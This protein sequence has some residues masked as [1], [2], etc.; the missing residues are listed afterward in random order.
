MSKLKILA[1]CSVLLLLTAE[2]AKNSIIGKWG[3]R[4]GDFFE[5]SAEGKGI[6]FNYSLQATAKFKWKII[7]S[8]SIKFSDPIREGS[9]TC[10]FVIYEMSQLEI[11]TIHGCPIIT[12]QGFVDSWSG[13]KGIIIAGK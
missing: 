6:A 12:S 1:L 5:F 10:G 13:R 11:L 2:K 7:T 8:T 3:S 4:D 9:T